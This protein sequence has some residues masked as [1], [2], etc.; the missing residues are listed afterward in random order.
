MSNDARNPMS[1]RTTHV[2]QYTGQILADVKFSDYSW[3]GKAMAVGIALHMG[4]L[5]LWSVLANTLVCLTVLLLCFTSVIM[6]WKRKP[7][8]NK[9]LMAPPLPRDMPMWKGAVFVG[10]F[11]SMAFPLAGLTLLAVLLADFI[12]I[13]R[14]PFLK[15]VLS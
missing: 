11:V 6:W 8:A 5:G 13:S 14:V 12:L 7:L 1:D 3:A 2:D 4:T 9:R 15:R 10:L